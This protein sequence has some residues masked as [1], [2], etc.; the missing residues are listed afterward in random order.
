MG[1]LFDL[2]PV[3]AFFV[4]YLMAPE[5]ST[6]LPTI[7]LVV[8]MGIQVTIQWLKHGSIKKIHMYS[9]ML[10]IPFAVLTVLYDS[11]D[12]LAWKFTIF[13][14]AIGIVILGA[15]YFYKV[16]LFEKLFIYI[17]KQLAAVP[18]NVWA[19]CNFIYAG[20]MITIGCINLLV[21]YN[22]ELSTWISFKVFGTMGLNIVFL[23]GLMIYLFKFI[24]DTEDIEQDEEEQ[25]KDPVTQSQDQQ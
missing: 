8:A 5:N 14:W 24:P 19:Q 18:A 12:F 9:F 10:L 23:V 3:L 1:I 4:A 2:F 25:R 15:F 6:L 13:H 7:T 11:Y 20:F 21:F 17:E 16:N 22:F